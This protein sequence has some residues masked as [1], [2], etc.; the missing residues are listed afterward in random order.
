MDSKNSLKELPF[1]E[2]QM[3]NFLTYFNGIM[4]LVVV[5]FENTA[6]YDHL[7]NL[8]KSSMLQDLKFGYNSIDEFNDICSEVVHNLE[9]S[10]IHLNIRSLNK[11]CSELYHFYI[12]S[13]LILMSLYY[14]RSGRIISLFII[15]SC[16]I[17]HFILIYQWLG[18]W[19]VLV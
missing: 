2:Y 4:N 10:V 7:I 15:I 9:T 17:I 3:L 13:I 6:F 1:I 18:M 14:L 8:N 19:V 16:L 11:N 12:C 5:V